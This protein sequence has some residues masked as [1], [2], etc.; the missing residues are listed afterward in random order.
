MAKVSQIP[1]GFTPV[2]SPVQRLDTLIRR[3]VTE[4][5]VLG[6]ASGTALSMIVGLEPVGD[7]RHWSRAFVEITNL[8]EEA[9]QQAASTIEGFDDSPHAR[10]FDEIL[11]VFQAVNLDSGWS[12]YA[13]QL[14]HLANIALPF[15]VHA[16]DG[17]DPPPVIQTDLLSELRNDLD[18]LLHKVLE[19]SFPAAFKEEFARNV[20]L[21]RDAIIRFHVYGPEGVGRAAV[22]VI[23]H[24]ALNEAPAKADKAVLKATLDL[25]SKI[26]EVFLKSVQ[27]GKIGAAVLKLLGPGL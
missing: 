27:I 21:L 11:K 2:P 5:Q 13:S 12:G 20:T 23:G 8:L 10:T 1:D 25:I 4:Q 17:F 3:A 16:T 24:V 22:Q 6:Q 14:N 18:S 26:Q 19:S 15:V 9:R 7:R